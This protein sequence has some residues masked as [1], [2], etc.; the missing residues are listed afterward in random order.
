M[1][2]KEDIYHLAETEYHEIKDKEERLALV[3][4]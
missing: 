3:E 1:A 2:G 4:R